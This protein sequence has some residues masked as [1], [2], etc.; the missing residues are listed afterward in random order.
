MRS[1]PTP[2]AARRHLV[3]DRKTAIL[4]VMAPT[5][6]LAA[7][8]REPK[9][10]VAASGVQ[11]K[12]RDT[13][14]GPLVLFVDDCDDVREMYSDFIAPAGL[15]AVGAVDGD[16]G[17]WKVFLLKPDVVVMDL[18]MPF[19]D[20]LEATAEIKTHPSTKHIPVVVLTGHVVDDNLRRAKDVGADMVLTKPCAPDVLLGVIKDL[21]ARA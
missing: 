18:A 16:H 7:R 2:A 9:R 8:H 5:G 1:Y 6:N 19:V 13:D 10:Y 4:K 21:L 17:L 3:S 14:L 20:G 11:R 15:R 12:V